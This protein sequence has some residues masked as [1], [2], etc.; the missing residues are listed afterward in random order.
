MRWLMIGLFVSVTA[1]LFVAGAVARHVWRQ[2]R[3]LATESADM[4]RQKV[5]NRELDLALD[6][7]GSDPHAP[8]ESRDLSS[9][10]L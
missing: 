8:T 9:S 1:L 5:E 10:E 3:L 2:R 4:D 6:L 7:H